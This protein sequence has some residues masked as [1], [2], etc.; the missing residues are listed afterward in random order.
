LAELKVRR[1]AEEHQHHQ[2][3]AREGRVVERPAREVET[4]GAAARRGRVVG[5]LHGRPHCSAKRVT[6]WPALSTCPPAATTSSPGFRPAATTTRL[7]SAPDTCTARG[8]T[9]PLAASNTYTMLPVRS[10]SGDCR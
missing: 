10:P 7:P 5:L 4:R 2:Q 3:V 6:F 9:V 8:C 1:D